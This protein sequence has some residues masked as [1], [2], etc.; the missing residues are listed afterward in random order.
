M[1]ARC[2]NPDCEGMLD[3]QQPLKLYPLEL[4]SSSSTL[5]VWLCDDCA[6]VMDV[7]DGLVLPLAEVRHHPWGNPKTAC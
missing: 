7:E 6:T 3:Y 5:F 4:Q 2:A 1:V